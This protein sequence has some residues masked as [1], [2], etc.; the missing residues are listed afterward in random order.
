[1]GCLLLS[2]YKPPCY[3]SSRSMLPMYILEFIYLTFFLV[4][5]PLCSQPNVFM[6]FQGISPL[7]NLT[8]WTWIIFELLLYLVLLQLL[9]LLPQKHIHLSY[10]TFVLLILSHSQMFWKKAR[11]LSYFHLDSSFLTHNIM[12]YSHTTYTN[13]VIILPCYK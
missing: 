2:R 6:H 10:F 3:S 8:E 12:L 1:M 11:L 9:C 13:W 4:Y 7:H 5:L